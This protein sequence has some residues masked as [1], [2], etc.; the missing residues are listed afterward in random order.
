[1][2]SPNGEKWTTVSLSEG[3]VASDLELTGFTAH[4]FGSPQVVVKSSD[5]L[6][7][8]GVLPNQSASL[9]GLVY[10]RQP[11]ASSEGTVSWLGLTE[12]SSAGLPLGT[13]EWLSDNKLP[14]ALSSSASATGLRLFTSQ[15]GEGR[16]ARV[17]TGNFLSGASGGSSFTVASSFSKAAIHTDRFTNMDLVAYQEGA[18]LKL[19]N[20]GHATTNATV[21]DSGVVD[22]AMAGYTGSARVVWENPSGRLMT[23]RV[24]FDCS[25]TLTLSEAVE[26]GGPAGLQNRPVYLAYSADGEG[27]G[28]ALAFEYR[29][30]SGDSPRLMMMEMSPS[31]DGWATNVAALFTSGAQRHPRLGVHSGRFQNQVSIG[32]HY[33]EDGG[34]SGRRLRFGLLE[35]ASAQQ[36]AYR[37]MQAASS[38]FTWTRDPLTVAE[39]EAANTQASAYRLSDLGAYLHVWRH[40]S[41]EIRTRIQVDPSK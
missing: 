36:A 5:E 35:P 39:P 6:S 22:F 11:S 12:G 27:A 1:M 14:S 38:P 25:G 26:V 40:N 31:E 28:G 4:P 33:E 10:H 15:D 37:L 13:G 2:K 30:A 19:Q 41:G 32:L 16:H 3:E 8:L 24:E 20:R 34:P 21:A 29:A 17:Y 7:L 9:K 18:A 23:R